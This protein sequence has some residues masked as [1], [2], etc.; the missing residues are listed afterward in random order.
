MASLKKAAI[1]FGLVGLA[2]LATGF[3]SANSYRSSIER[4]LRQELIAKRVS[5]RALGGEIIPTDEIA[6]ASRIKWPFV[7]EA[8]YFVPVDLHGRHHQVLY[9]ALPWGY[10]RLSSQDFLPV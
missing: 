8:S 4:E 3:V 5:G 2:A 9:L 10:R 6:V 7:V 1:V